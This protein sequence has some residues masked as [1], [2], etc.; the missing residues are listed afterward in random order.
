MPTPDFANMTQEQIDAWLATADPLD[1]GAYF[2]WQGQ[3]TGADSY[4]PETSQLAQDELHNEIMAGLTPSQRAEYQKKLDA[5]DPN[6]IETLGMEGES[7]GTLDTLPNPYADVA[8]GYDNSGGYD[9][10][11]DSYSN[12]MGIFA[13]QPA[14]EIPQEVFDIMALSTQSAST[15]ANLY[16]QQREDVLARLGTEHTTALDIL[17]LSKHRQIS[18]ANIMQSQ[19]LGSFRENYGQAMDMLGRSREEQL[20]EAGRIERGMLGDYDVGFQEAFGTLAGS[21]AEQLQRSGQMGEQMLGAY[22]RGYRESMGTL[23][24]SRAEQLGQVDVTGEQMLGA[25]GEGYGEAMGTMKGSRAQQLAEAGR[26]ERAMLGEYTREGEAALDILSQKAYGGLPGE[27]QYLEN[28]QAGTAAAV[29][30]LTRR[31]GGG[32]GALGAM[33][34]VYTGQ[35][36]QMRNLAAMRAQYQAQG[37]GELAGAR[38]QYGAGLAGIRGQAGAARLGVMSDMDKQIAAAQER[39]G[40][41]RADVYGQLGEAR[42]G[43]MSDIDRQIAAGQAEYGRGQADIYGQMGQVDVGIMSTMDR[44]LSQAQERYGTGRADIRG[45][46]GSERLGIMSTMDRQAAET[47]E[48]YGAG[49]AGIY[50]AG[51]KTRIGIESDMS[52]ATAGARADM[53]AQY[54]NAYQG[55]TAALGSAIDRG[56][57]YITS[58]LGDIAGERQ[59][60]FDINFYQPYVRQ[61]EFMI[62]EM[63]RTDPTSWFTQFA[64]GMAGV[65]FDQQNVGVAGQMAGV[66]TAVNTIGQLAGGYFQAKTLGQWN[67]PGGHTAGSFVY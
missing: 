27:Q 47:Q 66:D 64:A 7:G 23:D 4:T 52:Q 26:T 31:G 5:G 13:Q 28:L 17:G 45:M 41:G 56:T 67:Q 30:N 18:E 8:E 21:R 53:A 34:D 51:G 10:S 15:L 39:Y 14:Y 11:E 36:G 62:N 44:E 57:Q 38:Q 22:E 55:T 32:G 58:A 25:L 12:L 29:A 46:M 63:R 3:Q 48:R 6:P 1:R 42:L 49:L 37:M 65:T 59:K 9:Y 35:E 50:E 54:A 2:E 16:S 24:R 19:M 33:A 20:G 40:V 60:A 61:R 43:V